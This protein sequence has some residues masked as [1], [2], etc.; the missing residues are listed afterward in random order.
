GCRWPSRREIDGLEG[1]SPSTESGLQACYGKSPGNG[2]FSMDPIRRQLV[3][4]PPRGADCGLGGTA[5]RGRPACLAACA[6]YEP[7]R[8][9]DAITITFGDA[10]PSRSGFA[11]KLLRR[12]AA[13]RPLRGP[14]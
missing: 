10:I 9:K 4:L 6:G 7:P 3:R 5:R 11:P 1:W 2:A 14:V 12:R 13:G 8:D